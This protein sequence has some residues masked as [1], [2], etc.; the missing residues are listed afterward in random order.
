MKNQTNRP[1]WIN[2]L[3]EALAEGLED[4]RLPG[5][6]FEALASVTDHMIYNRNQRL[7]DDVRLLLPVTFER[8]INETE[9]PD[10]PCDEANTS[11][12]WIAGLVK[13]L[14]A[15]FKDKRLP[16]DVRDA[17]CT[18]VSDI[19]N[20][21]SADVVVSQKSSLS[22]A[23]ERAI[24][25]NSDADTEHD[26]DEDS[27]DDLS[28]EDNKYTTAIATII[29]D[30]RTPEYIGKTLCTIMSSIL[31]NTECKIKP[32]SLADLGELIAIIL[33][34]NSLPD[35][36]RQPFSDAATEVMNQLAKDDEMGSA[37]FRRYFEAATKREA[38]KA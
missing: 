2:K 11:P 36:V 27:H 28:D 13:D 24:N 15:A 16:V 37:W 12:A 23:L 20:R 22:I 31:D 5:Y 6:A 30:P 7:M 21:Y 29:T 19:E 9:N 8:A 10:Q 14:E 17:L 26:T 25:G 33:E 34:D 3:C 38:S 4:D 32:R 1:E 18:A 35:A